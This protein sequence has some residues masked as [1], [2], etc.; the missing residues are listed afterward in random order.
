MR[1]AGV[2]ARRALA[3]DANLADAHVAM[4][5][6]QWYAEWDF[7]G[8]D[9]SFRRAIEL[10]PSSGNA[11]AAYALFLTGTGRLEEAV[12]IGRR[13]VSLDPAL[14]G[15]APMDALFALGRHDEL[16]RDA[17]AGLALDS[18]STSSIYRTFIAAVM[19]ARGQKDSAL[20]LLR[21]D[22]VLRK[23]DSTID[24]PGYLAQAGRTAEARERVAAL[25]ARCGAT[26]G[27]AGVIAS[28]YA[29][30]GERARALDWLDRAYEVRNMSLIWS[31]R[32]VELAPLRQEPRYKAIM[33]KVGLPP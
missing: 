9:A 8:A 12:T 3:L 25:I 15:D 26:G 4:G 7:A 1:E 32:F 33:A 17:R 29:Y 31:G 10:E 5:E 2:L 14:A 21:R 27:C 19:L 6:L 18:L 22:A 24:S 20:A 11:L 13:A 28:G 30:L 23:G 16:L